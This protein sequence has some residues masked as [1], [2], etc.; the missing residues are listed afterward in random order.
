MRQLFIGGMSVLFKFF[1]IVFLLSC[2]PLVVSASG[3]KLFLEPD[4]GVYVVGEEFSTKV[5]IDSG[6]SPISAID[7]ALSFD[8]EKLEVVGVTLDESVLTD[9]PLAPQFSNSDGSVR[10][11][12]ISTL[13]SS[14]TRTVFS[15]KFRALINA[16][17]SVRFTRGS[18]ISANET[19]GTNLL[20][21]MDSAAFALT[22]ATS[23]PGED[24]GFLTSAGVGE[25]AGTST[26]QMESL[27][28]QASS[29]SQIHS[30][31]HPDSTQWYATSTAMLQWTNPAGTTQVRMLVDQKPTSRPTKLVKESLGEKRIEN[32]PE[33][34]SYFH[35][36]TDGTRGSE[37]VIHFAIHV[38][39]QTPESFVA[40]LAPPEDDTDP[41]SVFQLVATDTLSGIWR[42][43][44]ALDE[45]G[46]T[47]W[48]DNGTHQYSS[49]ALPPGDHVFHFRAFDR[50]GNYLTQ[51]VSVH[52]NPIT[53]PEWAAIPPQISER[54]TLT[55]TG[56]SH[57]N[58]D[59]EV[60]LFLAEGVV[61]KM[62]ATSDSN[63]IFSLE[64]AKSEELVPGT[65]LL[66]ARA[67]DGRGAQSLLSTERSIVVTHS[68]LSQILHMGKKWTP[69]IGLI[70]L[71][72]VVI[73]VLIRIIRRPNL[74]EE[75]EEEEESVTLPM[76]GSPS[77]SVASSQQA[78]LLGVLPAQHVQKSGMTVR[79]GP[80]RQK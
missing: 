7:G 67:T 49:G 69:K 3:V 42:Y 18:A 62:R 57:P 58:S 75:F 14:G 65:Y 12:G 11:S 5:L 55:V 31:T 40:T 2:D 60:F 72:F 27:D 78:P 8:P 1:L 54:D 56:K 41:K 35:L 30:S 19:T 63:G 6:V 13:G 70:V 50:A 51:D 23:A 61:K 28:A 80:P 39:T 46:E 77:I 22:T 76:A 24:I 45:G 4:S 25:V 44:I 17:A 71:I 52:I 16:P 53:T 36:E 48:Q 74:E 26:A 37:P 33:G 47:Y 64:L 38:D 34:I 29:S 79:I 66:S 15:V 20:T 59:I 43:G 10:W 73:F 68:L 9:W 32:L 21:R